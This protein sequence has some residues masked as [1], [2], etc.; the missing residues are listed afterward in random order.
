MSGTTAVAADSTT[1]T[2]GDLVR[3]WRRVRGM[4]QLDLAATAMTTPRYMSFLETGRSKPSRDMVLRLADALEVPLRDRN[5]LLL[6]AGF[7]PLYPHREL[8]DP[9]LTR[10]TLALDRMLGQHEP[11]PAVVMDR[12]W[13]LV[14]ANGGAQ[15]LFGRMF[16]PQPVP[17]AGNVLRL[18][19]EPGPVRSH[20]ANWEEVAPALL[21]RARR[22]AVGGVL[23]LATAEL[24]H[25]LRSRPDI[26]ALTTAPRS[27]APSSP[28]VDV[29]FRL[30]GTDLR[31]FSV[32]STIGTPIDV[33]A[34]ELRVEAFFPADDETADSWR[35]IGRP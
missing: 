17:G 1:A 14:R 2:F 13:N 25:E 19:L 23:D 24:V 30:G 7:A 9:T 21:E 22:E 18:I 29:H 27:I 6:A 20:V 8:D 34:Q 31:F 5:G 26:R 11:F 15:R 28:V 33:T 4:S 35:A 12:G 10:V 32:V 16:A 3:Y